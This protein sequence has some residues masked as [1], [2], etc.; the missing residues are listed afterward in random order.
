VIVATRV[1]LDRRRPCLACGAPWRVRM[2]AR[3]TDTPPG[4]PAVWEEAVGECSI[5]CWER[6]EDA[7]A[8]GLEQRALSDSV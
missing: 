2:R 5:R 6:D 7:Y 4:V 1:L 8:A 3:L